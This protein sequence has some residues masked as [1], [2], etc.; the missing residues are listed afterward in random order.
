MAEVRSSS[1][2]L[3]VSCVFSALGGMAWTEVAGRRR[4]RAGAL[5]PAKQ[6][7]AL[8]VLS[9]LFATPP[10]RPAAGQS[11]RGPRGSQWLCPKRACGCHNDDSRKLCRWC[12][13]GRPRSALADR[14][15][16]AGARAQPAARA[17][18]PPTSG[19]PAPAPAAGRGSAPAP[20]AGRGP[21]A[22]A[23][24]VPPAAA[25]AA[26]PA[27]A[28]PAAAP[29]AGAPWQRAAA[30]AE[31]REAEARAWEAAR[32]AAAAS[33]SP[34]VEQ[35]CAA[36]LARLAP[37]PRERP[38]TA[39]LQGTR[40]Y[41]G[42]ARRRVTAQEEEV[43]R[44]A[45]AL[46]AARADLAA[47]QQDVA[48]HEAELTR[49]EAEAGAAAAPAALPAALDAFLAAG[50]G[51]EVREQALALQRALAAARPAGVDVAMGDDA[52][53]ANGR[54]PEP[55]DPPQDQQPR[56]PEAEL[57]PGEVEPGEVRPPA[58]WPQPQA[59][60]GSAARRSAGGAG[61]APGPTPATG[62]ARE[63]APTALDSQGNEE[64]ERSRSPVASPAAGGAQ[65]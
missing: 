45:A 37:A 32:A 10:P 12:G 59:A 61:H 57:E 20:A 11:T 6:Q 16:P 55:S 46:E 19:A 29:A 36:A 38:L 26:A 7:Q 21:A 53:R 15:A 39:R 34:V 54:A 62:A 51:P 4:Q 40:E 30:A 49:L 31:A 50:V 43:A 3:P 22:A 24:A 64:R 65:R 18:A 17:P 52:A 2:E 27:A 56:A 9:A 25:E 44:A 1:C 5:T 58:Q 13:T 23:A 63:V 35:T 28:P 47:L 48:A 60:A 8:E 33:G 41:L 42:R 14:A